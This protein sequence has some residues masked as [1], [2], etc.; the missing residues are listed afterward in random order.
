MEKHYFS[1]QC[2]R[3][4]YIAS[5]TIIVNVKKYFESESLKKIATLSPMSMT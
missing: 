2:I 5:E 3:R 1:R 4:K